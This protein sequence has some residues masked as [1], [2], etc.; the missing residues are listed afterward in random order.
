MYVTFNREKFAK[1][2][3][4]KYVGEGISLRSAAKEIGVSAPTLSRV[5]DGKSPDI[6]SFVR[7]IVWLQKEPKAY[8]K[9]QSS[10]K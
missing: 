3:F 5:T 9:K 1:D 10:K 7:I 4:F 8:F 6:D 2:V